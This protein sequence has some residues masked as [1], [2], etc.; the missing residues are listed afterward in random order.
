MVS[1][2]RSLTTGARAGASLFLVASLLWT[3]P[4]APAAARGPDSFADLA[5][6]LLPA[7]VNI[8]STQVSRERAQR[9]PEIPQSP[10]GSPFE[11][12]FRDFM[13]RN[14][15]DAPPRRVTSLGSGFIIDPAG[16]VVTNNHVIEDADEISVILQDNTTLKAKVVGKDTKTDLALLKE[17]GR[18]HV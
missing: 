6:K 7:V 15:P 3:V 1:V 10:P 5:E 2:V 8:S 13:D 12:F 4:V 16:F 18:A 17:I 9:G 14:R 11:E